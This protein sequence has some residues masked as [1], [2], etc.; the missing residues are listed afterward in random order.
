MHHYLNILWQT[1]KMPSF[2][3]RPYDKDYKKIWVTPWHPDFFFLVRK[4]VPDQ[5]TAQI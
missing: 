5:K 3:A 4:Y 2:A 1:L